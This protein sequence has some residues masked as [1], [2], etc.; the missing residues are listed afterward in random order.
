MISIIL[1]L[2]LIC[3]S[4]LYY[5]LEKYIGMVWNKNILEELATK[6]T[7]KCLLYILPKENAIHLIKD[8]FCIK[9]C[10]KYKALLGGHP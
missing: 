10:T 6:F 4:F 9:C 3:T 5:F 1:S 8:L 2:V 7:S